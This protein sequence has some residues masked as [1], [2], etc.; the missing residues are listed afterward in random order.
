[1]ATF[2]PLDEKHLVEWFQTFVGR[3]KEFGPSLRLTDNDIRPVENDSAALSQLVNGVSTAR[4]ATPKPEMLSQLENYKDLIK[5]GPS[6][7]LR[8]AF[9][10]V[11]TPPATL[12]AP[13]VVP[14]LKQLIAQLKGSPNYT[15]AIGDDLDIAALSGPSP[16][17]TLP[18][19]DN[20]LL[21]WYRHFLERLPTHQQTFGLSNAAVQSAHNDYDALAHLV[22]G[23]DT[24]LNDHK[25]TPHFQE[26]VSYKNLIR[27]G[28]GDNLR[29]AFPAVFTPVVLATAPGIIP[30]LLA[31]VERLKAM[32]GFLT[33]MGERLGFLLPVAAAAA[34]VPVMPTAPAAPVR[35]AA[36]VVAATEAGNRW[37]I[38][39]L[40]GLLFLGLL[41]WWFWGNRGPAETPAATPAP[42]IAADRKPA[43]VLMLYEG[44]AK[45][46][47]EPA[48]DDFNKQ[49]QGQGRILLTP[50]GSRDSRDQILYDKQQ[51]HPVVWTPADSY[52]VDKLQMDAANPNLPSK[53]GATVYGGKPLLET[54]LVLLMQE[55]RAK[56]FEAAM[57][58]PEYKGHTWKL[59]QDIATN[60]WASVGGSADWGKLKWIQSSPTESNSAMTA[61]ALMYKEYARYHPGKDINSPDF[62]KEMTDIEG[63][64]NT[65]TATTSESLKELEDNPSKYDMAVVYESDAARALDAG[66]KGLHVVYPVPTAHIVLPAA[67][68][69]AS[70][71]SDKQAQLGQAFIAYLLRD[72]VQERA[73]KQGYR[74]VN[75]SLQ[76]K[77]DAAYSTPERQA[78][79]LVGEP[80]TQD[81]D[82]DTKTKEGLIYN[83]D[84]WHQKQGG[85]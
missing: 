3:L 77:E 15:A 39:A 83:W 81:S 44:G 31:F 47:L 54:T 64:V 33:S 12:V 2:L 53:S 7:S 36:S 52:W 8:N 68:V 50:L 13:G 25:A 4:A 69:K 30:R 1:M 46:W 62:Q 27:D 20:E 23:V 58:K 43:D 63:Q 75:S 66:A 19:G 6:E 49:H 74:L 80:N 35:T 41:G 59:L 57:Q 85:Q 22:R 5:S 32:P 11:F 42:V 56:V 48:A 37:L 82:T 17:N 26:L 28:V 67:I 79:G 73:L 16:A 10:A 24:A 40:L 14:R 18:T 45:G 9:P 21:G 70:W 65:L 55:D 78:S 61:L 34:A 29:S 76:A 38:P 72:D 60:G 51:I 71:V 84:Q